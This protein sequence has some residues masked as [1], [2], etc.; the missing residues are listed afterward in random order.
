MIKPRVASRN[1]RKNLILPSKLPFDP[2]KFQIRSLSIGSGIQG[3]DYCDGFAF[4]N[5]VK[6]RNYYLP[7]RRCLDGIGRMIH[8]V[9]SADG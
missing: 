2:A 9:L 5:L 7:F 3:A 1:Y 4:G 6:G 8:R